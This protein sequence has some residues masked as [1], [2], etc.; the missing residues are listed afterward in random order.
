LKHFE[1]KTEAIQNGQGGAAPDD[2]DMGE[3]D[4]QPE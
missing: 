4:D 2:E 3:E 1:D